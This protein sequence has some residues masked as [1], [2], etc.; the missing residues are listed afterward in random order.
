MLDECFAYREML[1]E[2]MKKLKKSKTRLIRKIKNKG[3]VKK[4]KTQRKRLKRN[5]EK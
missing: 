1:V 3:E 4:T 2:V 5:E